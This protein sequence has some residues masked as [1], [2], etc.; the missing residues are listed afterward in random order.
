MVSLKKPESYLD[1]PKVPENIPFFWYILTGVLIIVLIIAV[2][3][4][5]L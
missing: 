1:N 4:S 3:I 5:F 2:I